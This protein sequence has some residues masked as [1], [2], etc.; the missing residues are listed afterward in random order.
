MSEKRRDSKNRILRNG[1]SQRKD[2]RYAYKY[3]DATGKPRFVYSWKLEPTD[4]LPA[5]KRECRSL[6]ELEKEIEKSLN[7]ELAYHGGDVTVLELVER[8]IATKTGVR[9][10]T[11]AGYKTVVNILKK[12]EF[13]SRR[14]DLVKPSDAKL[15]LIKLQSED[16]RSY[17]SIHSIRGLCALHSVWLLRMT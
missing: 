2:G 15:W 1:E 9:H 10:N 11:I 17:S 12:E 5:G 4:K 6:R 8:Y 3:I 16:K 7:K 14:I 13:G